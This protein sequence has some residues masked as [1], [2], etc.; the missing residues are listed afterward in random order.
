MTNRSVS[1]R[2]SIPTCPYDPTGK[3][4]LG[5]CSKHYRRLLRTGDP[6]KVLKKHTPGTGA[7]PK[8]R[9]WSRVAITANPNKCWD[10]QAGL[11]KDGYGKVT[12]N[13]NPRTRAHR[14]A[15]YYTY[16]SLPNGILRHTCDNPLCVNPNHLLE[17]THADNVRDKVSRNR[18]QKGEAV[19]NS[20]L[21]EADVLAIR[22]LLK[23]ANLTQSAIAER[24]GVSRRSIGMIKTGSTWRHVT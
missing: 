17:G 10:W 18:Q 24:F 4:V 3:I 11:S 6:E 7:T 19:P 13:G 15:W 20:V 14:A 21:K 2:C 1:N 12:L 23:T 22:R 5:Y 8:E 9:F 16:G